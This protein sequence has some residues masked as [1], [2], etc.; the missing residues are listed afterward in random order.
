MG[1]MKLEG[2]G[3]NKGCGCNQTHFYSHISASGLL[4]RGGKGHRDFT[5]I[6]EEKVQVDSVEVRVWLVLSSGSRLCVEDKK[7]NADT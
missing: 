4:K 6:S 7:A 5:G 1:L 3:D 2:K